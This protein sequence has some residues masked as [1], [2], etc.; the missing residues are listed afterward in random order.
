MPGRVELVG[1]VEAESGT[2]RA[3]LSALDAVYV[4][5]QVDDDRGST[6]TRILDE[7]L[8]QPFLVR[9]ASGECVRVKVAHARFELPEARRLPAE[10]AL[11]LLAKRGKSGFAPK[12]SSVVRS[13]SCR[14]RRPI[15]LGSR[16][17][18]RK[19]PSTASPRRHRVPY[20]TGI[21]S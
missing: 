19:A 5:T 3:P 7:P 2:V 16:V 15:F 10:R 1:V 9:D 21:F 11:E 4:R 20:W 6:R 13:A 14:A 18:G 8:H 12:I 17:S